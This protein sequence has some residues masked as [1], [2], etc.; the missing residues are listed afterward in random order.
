MIVYVPDCS[1]GDSEVVTSTT[2]TSSPSS[3][4]SA[5]ISVIL[6]LFLIALI[7]AFVYVYGRNNPGGIA[8]RWV[9]ITL[10]F[11]GQDYVLPGYARNG[12][13]LNSKFCQPPIEMVL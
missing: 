5:V 9:S 11:T 12:T 7:A 3:V 2:S 6:V 4:V 13:L 10:R 8:A 1:L